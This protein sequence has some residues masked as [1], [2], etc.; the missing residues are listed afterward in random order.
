[1]SLRFQLI[2]G[3]LTVSAVALLFQNWA[4]PL[5]RIGKETKTSEG[6]TPPPSPLPPP[7]PE[8][9]PIDSLFSTALNTEGV[10]LP[11]GHRDPHYQIFGSADNAWVWSHNSY[12]RTFSGFIRF[13][14]KK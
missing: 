10:P 8:P 13:K 2:L 4:E 7:K 12:L 1:M 5:P 11:A 14:V 9:E 3:V 6:E